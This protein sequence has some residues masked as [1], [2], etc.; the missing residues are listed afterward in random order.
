MEPAE[1]RATWGT[2]TFCGDATPP[3]APKCVT[4]G[5]VL[6]R[7]APLPRR[8][9]HWM[10]LVKALRI[11]IVVGV[12]AAL[13][14]AIVSAQLAGPTTFSDPLTGTWTMNVSAGHYVVLSGNITGEDYIQGNY[15][16]TSPPGALA[17]LFVL[18]STEISPFLLGYPYATAAPP[19]N[20]TNGLIVFDAPYTDTFYFV[21]LNPYPATSNITET[22]YVHTTYESNVVLG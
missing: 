11:V 10:T 22:I 9:K 19:S 7:G 1:S 6:N 12:V 15:S 5:Q 14:W 4:C 16:V 21:Y 17:T 3:G 2:C 8:T 20:G 13:G 18:N